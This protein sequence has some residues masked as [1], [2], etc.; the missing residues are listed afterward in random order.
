MRNDFGKASKLDPSLLT[1]EPGSP[2]GETSISLD[3]RAGSGQ[4]HAGVDSGW[5][6]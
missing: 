4:S 1:W 6:R 2:Q 3:S 5:T